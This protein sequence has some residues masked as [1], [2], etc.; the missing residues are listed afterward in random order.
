LLAA[1]AQLRDS[2]AQRRNVALQT[3]CTMLL[4]LLAPQMLRSGT[5][6]I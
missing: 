1:L 4:L 2:E 6:A 5:A 3:P